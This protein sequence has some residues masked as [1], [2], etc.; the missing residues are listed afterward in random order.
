MVDP[1]RKINHLSDDDAAFLRECEQEFR[2][3]FTEKDE[4]FEEFC[5]KPSRSAPVITPW[6][7]SGGRQNGPNQSAPNHWR[8]NNHRNNSGGGG[9]GGGGYRNNS[10][11]RRNDN[12]HYRNPRNFNNRPRGPHDRNDRN[13]RQGGNSHGGAPARSSHSYNNNRHQPY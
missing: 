1:N 5:K 3:R 8:N 10:Y 7:T 11:N 12:N 9:G 6:A 2:Y 4:E 13:Y